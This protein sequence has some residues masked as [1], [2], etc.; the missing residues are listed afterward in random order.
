MR[1][2]PRKVVFLTLHFF[3]YGEDFLRDGEA[4][5]MKRPERWDAC[6]LGD[7]AVLEQKAAIKGAT[8]LPSSVRPCC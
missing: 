1:A 4:G 5:L 2:N 8:V 7:D 3:L 6:V